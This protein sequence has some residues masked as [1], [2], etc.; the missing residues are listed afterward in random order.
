MWGKGEISFG[1][2][3]E[4]IEPAQMKD[5]VRNDLESTKVHLH[6]LLEKEWTYNPKKIL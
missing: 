6:S 3:A 1:Q 5:L 2:V 4:V